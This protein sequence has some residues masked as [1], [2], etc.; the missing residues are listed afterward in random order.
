M[1]I[2][3]EVPGHGPYLCYDELSGRYVMSS[4]SMLEACVDDLSLTMI[5]DGDVM[6]NDF[7]EAIGLSYIALAAQLRWS[8]TKRLRLRFNAILT[9]EGY[10]AINFSFV[11]PPRSDL[12]L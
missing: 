10:P 8:E 1:T 2:T 5:E 9:V 12:R 7:Y 11:T 4:I 6:L 3:L